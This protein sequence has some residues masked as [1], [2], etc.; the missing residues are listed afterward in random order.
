MGIQPINR[1]LRVEPRGFVRFDVDVSN[2]LVGI[3][4]ERKFQTRRSKVRNDRVQFSSIYT[5]RIYV[6]QI[7][8]RNIF[9]YFA[10]TYRRMRD[11]IWES[12]PRAAKLA[13]T[14]QS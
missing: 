10:R 13:K 8:V 6:L 4:S 11:E 2:M 1:S 14:S 12:A 3:A 9:P 5:Y 7:D